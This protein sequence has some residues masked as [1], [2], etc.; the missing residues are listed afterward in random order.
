MPGNDAPEIFESGRAPTDAVLRSAA[1]ADRSPSPDDE[2]A[3]RRPRLWI[4]GTGF[5]LAALLVVGDARSP[6]GRGIVK[7]TGN[8][9]PAYYGTAHSLLFDHDFDLSNE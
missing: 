7:I 9:P 1:P 5:L 3:V 6:A 2:A 8:D 4:L